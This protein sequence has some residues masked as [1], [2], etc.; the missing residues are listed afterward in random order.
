MITRFCQLMF[1]LLLL[2]ILI[3]GGLGP[4]PR[5][6]ARAAGG[7]RAQARELLQVGHVGERGGHGGA[8][9]SSSSCPPPPPPPSLHSR[10][11]PPPRR[12][13]LGRR[14]CRAGG[15]SAG[16]VR[17]HTRYGGPRGDR[18]AAARTHE[19]AA[20]RLRGAPRQRLPRAV[21]PRPCRTPLTPPARGPARPA[22]FAEFPRGLPGLGAGRH[23]E[24]K[25]GIFTALRLLTIKSFIPGVFGEC[26]L[27][28]E[29]GPVVE[30]APDLRRAYDP[31]G[32][33]IKVD[34]NK[35]Y[36]A[37]CQI[38]MRNVEPQVF[39]RIPQV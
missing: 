16:C 26:P 4:A 33:A 12:P 28:T 24:R 25:P 10:P 11:S 9:S 21:A 3:L 22:E 19:E 1:P 6:R 13:K 37:R 36:Y 39:N 23:A 30:Q 5:R 38:H 35:K 31:R 18:R 7:Q 34:K 17:L 27:C 29:A 14:R 32:E 15:G 2:L 20:A 8:C